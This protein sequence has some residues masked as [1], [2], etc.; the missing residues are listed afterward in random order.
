MLGWLKKCRTYRS[1]QQAGAGGI[2]D[3]IKR[4]IAGCAD[5]E[6]QSIKQQIVGT[7]SFV[8]ATID[9]GDELS[10]VLRA[11]RGRRFSRHQPSN[12]ATRHPRSTSP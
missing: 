3:E 4:R 8:L 6:Q 12:P 11:R 5:A 1:G 7:Y 9:R 2:L 10:L